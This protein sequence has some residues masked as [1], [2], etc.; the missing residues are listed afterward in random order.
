[1]HTK[2]PKNG[3]DE[4]VGSDPAYF[5]SRKAH[6]LKYGYLVRK[7]RMGAFA[8]MILGIQHEEAHREQAYGL[9]GF[10]LN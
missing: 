6:G 9:A 7:S 1:M 5:L 2:N 3:R 10:S 4:V 8:F